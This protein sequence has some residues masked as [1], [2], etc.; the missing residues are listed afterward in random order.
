GFD[1]W[2]AFEAVKSLEADLT[3][4]SA[5]LFLADTYGN[6]PDRTQTLSREL[7]QY[8]FYAP[9]NRN[10][11][12]NFSEYTALFDQP[13]RQVTVTPG[14]GT[15]GWFTGNVVS[16]SGN[17]RFA[18]NAFIEHRGEDGGRP[19]RR[20]QNTTGF[21]QAKVSLTDRDTLFASF[22]DVRRTDG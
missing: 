5:H 20:D 2:G 13:M 14:L 15:D 9:V 7:L 17:Q 10:S 1:A 11:F 21:A 3:N 18:H 4:A 19:D 6:L 8:F 22:L 16:R 12:N